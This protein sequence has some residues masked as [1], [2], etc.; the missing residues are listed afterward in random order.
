MAAFNEPRRSALTGLAS[1]ITARRLA[2][3]AA[4]GAA[5]AT[6]AAAVLGLSGGTARS[7]SSTSFP[8]VQA[9]PAPAGWRSATLPDGAVLAYPPAMHLVSGDLGSASAARVGPG[10]A[11]L[12]Y[13]NATPRQGSESLR[14]WPGFRISHL[15]DDDASSARELMAA[16]GVRF[17]GGTGACIVDTYVTK[18]GAHHFTELACLVH[19]SRASSVIVAAAPAADWTRSASLLG[20]AV[21]AY[22]AR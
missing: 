7:A 2:L 10:G 6:L 19:G 5:A 21:A 14:N 18:V 20:R 9:R 11:Y 4:V 1:R 3:A 15:L 17:L 12:L 8:L 13:L 16:S 22:Q